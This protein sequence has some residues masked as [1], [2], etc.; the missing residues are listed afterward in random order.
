MTTTIVVEAKE[1]STVA[2]LGVFTDED[3]DAVTPS[4]CTWTL[5]DLSGDVINS[6]AQVAVSSLSSSV[7]IVLS[8]ADL[9][10]LATEEDQELAYRYLVVEA[11][12]TSSLGAGMPLK[13]EIFFTVRNLH[14][15][16]A[17]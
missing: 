9:Q 16:G 13:D 8:G 17:S 14:Y 6:R 7:S 12:Y 4:A 10:I 1:R 2:F 3:G 5:T 15:V 11:T